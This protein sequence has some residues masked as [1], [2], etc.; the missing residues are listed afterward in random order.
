MN[1]FITG[2]INVNQLFEI[3]AYQNKKVATKKEIENV[4]NNNFI[5]SVL[6]AEHK[7]N[8]KTLT[9]KLTLILKKL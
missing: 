5:L 7:V 3:A 8:K 2:K 9:E 4:L 6:C 1:D